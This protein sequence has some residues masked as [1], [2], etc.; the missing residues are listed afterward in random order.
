MITIKS[1]REID[2]MR[3]AGRLVAE[4]LALMEEHVK[5][6]V[7]TL[8]LNEIADK[9]IRKHGGIPSF[10]GYQGFPA[11]IC[12]SPNEVVVHG[13][14]SEETVL[15]EGDILSV[16]VGAIIDGY[17]GDAARTIPCGEISAEAQQL[18]DVTRESFFK[19]LEQALAG[20][21]LSDISHAIQVHAEA[22]GYGVVRDFCGHGIGSSMH[23]APQIPNYGNPGFGPRLRPGMCL[24]VEPM[25]NMGTYEVD[26]LADGWTT[27]TR[28]GKLSCHYENTF[29]ITDNQAEILTAL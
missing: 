21:R 16:D 22:Y 24:A 7:T 18:I 4:T 9:H 28:D 5:P 29:V 15:Q 27:V 1:Q 8:E 13:I 17:H 14:P 19:G 2:V 20:N 10:Y 11:S 3:E 12:A 26:I 6:G 23:E 25:I